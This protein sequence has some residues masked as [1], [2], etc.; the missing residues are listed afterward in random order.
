MARYN[1]N[2]MM[3]VNFSTCKVLAYSISFLILATIYDCEDGWLL[4]GSSCYLFEGASENWF[5]ARVVCQGYGG[6]LAVIRDEETNEFLKSKLFKAGVRSHLV[7]RYIRDC[8]AS[9]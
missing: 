2:H 6:D 1:I 9:T 8:R 5:G 7:G 4:K 3:L